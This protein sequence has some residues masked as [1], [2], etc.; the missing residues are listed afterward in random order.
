MNIHLSMKM[1]WFFSI[2][3]SK[4]KRRRWWIWKFSKFNFMENFYED[5][6]PSSV[7]RATSEGASKWNETICFLAQCSR[8]F[9][10]RWNWRD[11]REPNGARTINKFIQIMTLFG[12]WTLFHSIIVAV[13]LPYILSI[14]S[15]IPNDTHSTQNVPKMSCCKL[16]RAKASTTNDTKYI[17]RQDGT[18]RG[19]KKLS[20][21]FSSHFHIS[22]T[23]FPRC[24]SSLGMFRTQHRQIHNCKP[25]TR[26]NDTTP[27][28]I[29]FSLPQ[30]SLLNNLFTLTRPPV[31]ANLNHQI[32][33]LLCFTVFSASE[34]LSP[35]VSTGEKR[36]N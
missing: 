19:K 5:N 32:L 22:I 18:K 26:T 15:T 6:F 7:H 25:K 24:C 31:A 11:D 27:V 3:R 10:S 14:V 12:F 30:F 8:L 36:G 2:H 35:T 23:I 1:R 20:N 34:Q 28:L 4:A 33:F 17:F 21:F 29:Y 13:S 9:R 16:A